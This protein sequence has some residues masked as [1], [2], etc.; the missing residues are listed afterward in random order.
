M[1]DLAEQWAADDVLIGFPEAAMLLGV[2]EGELQRLAAD[3]A[4]DTVGRSTWLSE[5]ERLAIARADREI[6]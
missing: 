6:A 3:Q 1:R 5:V 4:I 2:S